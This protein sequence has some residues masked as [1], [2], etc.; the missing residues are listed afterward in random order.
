MES[1]SGNSNKPI[2]ACNN[3]TLFISTTYLYLLLSTFIHWIERDIC[4]IYLSISTLT[5][6]GN[7]PETI[8]EKLFLP[9]DDQHEMHTKLKHSDQYHKFVFKNVW[10]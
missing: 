10:T 7:S 4:H 9:I 6:H 1:S 2:N 3:G 8:R 5:N